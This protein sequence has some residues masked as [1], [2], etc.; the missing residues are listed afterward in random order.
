MRYGVSGFVWFLLNLPLI[1]LFLALWVGSFES[2]VIPYFFA[3]N[4][5]H[6]PQKS[7]SLVSPYFQNLFFERPSLKIGPIAA[8]EAHPDPPQAL[9]QN[10][11]SMAMKEDFDRKSHSHGHE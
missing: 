6:A 4:S 1:G 9:H 3:Q 11:H 10:S 8:S 5:L 7:R 2:D